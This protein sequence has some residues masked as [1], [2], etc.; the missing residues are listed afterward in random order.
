MNLPPQP[1]L[2]VRH[3]R[4]ERLPADGR[5]RGPSGRF[6]DLDRTLIAG[7][8]AYILAT[9]ARFM[10][11]VPT[12]QF[13][14]DAGAAALQAPGSTDQTME[15]VRAR[16]LAW[17][18]AMRPDD[19][20]A[21]ELP[22]LCLGCWPGSVPRRAAFSTS[23]ATPAATTYIVSAAPVEIVEPLAQSLGMTAGIGTRSTIVDVAHSGE[24]AGPLVYGAGKVVA[25]EGDRLRDGL[26]LAQCCR[27][28]R[29]GER[30][31]DA[32]GGRPSGRR[33][34]DGRLARH[35]QT[36]ALAD[37]PLQPAYMK[38]RDPSPA[39]VAGATAIAVLLRRRH[40]VCRKGE[41][42]TGRAV[43]RCSPVRHG[44]RSSAFAGRIETALIRLS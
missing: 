34:P 32:R 43:Q 25:M 5:C 23:I 20:V 2:Q 40:E 31:A 6:F 7:S 35:A 16:I 44:G 12:R 28:Q 11:L 24:L 4:C 8:S 13:V 42:G 18:G 22:H 9:A 41:A 15:D 10:G 27:L 37:R 29:L 26:D 21:L 38:C 14:R 30:P 39:T 36:H 33:Q 3:P 17:V 19:L 1:T